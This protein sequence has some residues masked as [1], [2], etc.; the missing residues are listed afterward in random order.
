MLRKCPHHGVPEW[1]QIQTFYQGLS[2]VGRSNV[3]VAVGGRSIKK[4]CGGC[5]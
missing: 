3:D 1:M 2:E 4:K 5:I